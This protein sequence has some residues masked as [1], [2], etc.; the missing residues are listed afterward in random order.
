MRN[1]M[2]AV[3]ATVA[4]LC[5]LATLVPA[6]AAAGGW[7]VVSSWNG[8]RTYA[9]ASPNGDG[10]SRI[11]VYWDGRSYPT[12]DMGGG[13]SGGAGGLAHVSPVMEISGWTY[14]GA[15]KGDVGSVTS[16]VRPDNG[17]VYFISGSAYGIM[18]EVVMP[19]SAVSVCPGAQRATGD[20][21]ADGTADT[22]RPVEAA[23]AS[24]CVTTREFGRLK[25]GMTV[26]KVRAVVGARGK[27]VT[28]ADYSMVRRYPRCG[29]G[30]VVVN[31]KKAKKA[32]PLA[33]G[34]RYRR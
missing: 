9:C 1:R 20:Q 30:K 32:K 10:T 22:A 26:R 29:G 16:L 21:A 11:K 7:E 8:G 17:W 15:D 25:K 14:S 13:T 19:V 2:L 33:L 6:P 28:V 23:T 12:R 31:F 34:S 3:A 27:A 5:G 4:M 18:V 24:R